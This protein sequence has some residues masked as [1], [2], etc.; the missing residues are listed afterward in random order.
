MSSNKRLRHVTGVAQP[1]LVL[2]DLTLS[3]STIAEGTAVGTTIGTVLGRSPNSFL[4][5]TGDAGGRF[6]LSGT[7]LVAGVV[8]TD[9]EAFTSHSITIRETL[10]GSSNSPHDTV[11]TISV[12]NVTEIVLSVLGG[13]FTLPESASSGDIAGSITGASVG[14]TLSL[15]DSAGGKVDISG[16][17]VVRGFTPL[18]YEAASSFSFV[19][20]EDNP[21]ALNSPQFSVLSLTVTNVYEQPALGTLSLSLA[22][23]TPSVPSSGTIIGATAGSTITSSGLPAGLLVNGVTRTWAWDGTGSVSSGTLTLTETLADSLGSPKANSISWVISSSYLVT[24]P[25]LTINATDPLDWSI[26]TVDSSGAVVGDTLR[27]RFKVNGG[28]YTNVD[29]V[30]DDGELVSGADMFPQ[31]DFGSIVNGDIVKW[32]VCVFRAGVQVSDWSNEA[33]WTTVIHVVPYPQSLFGGTYGYALDPSDTTT[34]FKQIDGTS[35]VTTAGDTVGYIAD[36]SGNTASFAATAN[37]ST[38]PTWDSATSTLVFDGVDATLFRNAAGLYAAGAAT[39]IMA[40]RGAAQNGHYFLSECNSGS[41]SPFYVPGTSAGSTTTSAQTFIRNDAGG[42]VVQ[43]QAGATV[44]DDTLF[45]MTVTDSGSQIKI[46]KNRSLINTVAYTRGTTTL[47][48]TGLGS[49][50]RSSAANWWSGRVGRVLAIGRALT[51]PELA[52]A[53]NWVATAHGI[54]LP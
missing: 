15:A 18:N 7:T 27:M 25:A 22:H 30:L 49:L 43:N 21:N 35:A 14:S 32:N 29:R 44:W 34:L 26:D 16:N 38:R 17:N 54:T 13:T 45:I 48:R 50:Y 24:T 19:V 51:A 37:G 8:P 36:L 6:A 33:T 53:E 52:T 20:R 5:L 10:A 46:Y 23:F 2:P 28:A 31:S 3:F 47:N 4:S 42:T 41:T 11:L 9:Y 1:P 40:V 12:T 39:I